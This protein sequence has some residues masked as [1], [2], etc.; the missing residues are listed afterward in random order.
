MLQSGSDD[1][2]APGDKVAIGGLS[3]I[4]FDRKAKEGSQGIRVAV[5]PGRF[6]QMPDGRSTR[7]AVV[8]NFA[9]IVM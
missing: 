5:H 4:A 9:A 3:F 1:Q 2:C 6:N 8:S 7:E